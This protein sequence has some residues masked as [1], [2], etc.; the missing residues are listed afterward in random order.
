MF[1]RLTQ[2]IVMSPLRQ[3]MEADMV[4]RGLALRTRETYV[5]WVARF[6]KFHGKR[7]DRLGE[8][9]VERYLLHL[10]EERKLAQVFARHGAAFQAANR[11]VPVQYR[12]MRA[13]ATCRTEALGGHIERCDACAALRY[14]YHSCR[15]R[16]CPQCQTLAKERWLAA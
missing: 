8:E 12:A 13:I 3:Q 6:A 15:N 7:P 4:V 11:L 9:Q 14:H 2:E 5:E 10:L 1:P 16:H